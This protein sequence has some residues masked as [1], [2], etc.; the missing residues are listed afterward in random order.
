MNDIIRRANERYYKASKWTSRFYFYF[1]FY[2]KERTL[3]EK[4]NEP[5]VLGEKN[6][7]GMNRCLPEFASIVWYLLKRLYIYKA[8]SK[9]RGALPTSPTS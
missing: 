7:W 5:L 6:K 3:G 2:Y 8:A 1:Y 4:K 9:G